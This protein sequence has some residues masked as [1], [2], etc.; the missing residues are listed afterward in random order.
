[1]IV[2]SNK[3][4]NKNLV[5][6]IPLLKWNL[7][8]NSRLGIQLQEMQVSCGQSKRCTDRIIKTQSS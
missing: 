2:L 4:E 1:M 7:F 8:E 5:T 6:Y 3:L